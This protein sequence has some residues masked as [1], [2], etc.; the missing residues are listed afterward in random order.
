M[1]RTCVNGDWQS[2]YADTPNDG[3]ESKKGCRDFSENDFN[4]SGCCEKMKGQSD[5]DDYSDWCREGGD[6]VEIKPKGSTSC[7]A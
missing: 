3:C 1:K 4:A 7:A 5:F 6:G 2:S